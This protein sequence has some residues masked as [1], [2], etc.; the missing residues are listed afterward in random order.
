V[1]V[2]EPESQSAGN[3]MSRNVIWPSWVAVVAGMATGVERGT[4]RY[5]LPDLMPGKLTTRLIRS[6]ATIAPDELSPGG[7]ENGGNDDG[8]DG[9]SVVD[10]VDG[11]VGVVVE[12]AD[13][14]V[15]VDVPGGTVGV[16]DVVVV[17]VVVVVVTISA[18]LNRAGAVP[19][20]LSAS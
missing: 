19:W 5:R 18:T 8:L 14:R 9:G 4:A 17:I 1:S 16:D 11:T 12:D 10:V 3:L 6:P 13:R 2:C 15:V 20:L 7:P